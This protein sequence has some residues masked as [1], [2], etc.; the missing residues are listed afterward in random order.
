MKATQKFSPSPTDDLALVG[1]KVAAMRLGSG[2]TGDQ[3]AAA[4]LGVHSQERVFLV[5]AAVCAFCTQKFG[6]FVAVCNLRGNI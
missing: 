4:S 5:A 1:S 3:A 2:R 6:C